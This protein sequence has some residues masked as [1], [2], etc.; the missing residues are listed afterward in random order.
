M[1][2]PMASRLR[3]T[4]IDDIA[5]QSHLLGE[6]APL[7]RA[8]EE[9]QQFSFVLWGGP[10]TGKTTIA[11]IYA[12]AVG[13]MLFEL[14]AVSAKKSDVQKVLAFGSIEAPP[15]LFLDEIHRFT[16]AQ[17]DV[18]LP[19]LETG[20]IILIGATTENPSFEVNAALLSRMRVFPLYPLSHDELL[21]IADRTEIPLSNEV[22]DIL[23]RFASGDARVL[24]STIETVQATYG[25]VTEETIESVVH[26]SGIRYDKKGDAHYDI[27]SALI[28]SMRASQPDAALYYLARM[29]A[30]GED[31]KF[32]A[33]RLVIFASEDIGQAAP[34]ALVVANEVFRAVE[35]IGLPEAEINLAHG[36]VYLAEAQ[37]DR[38]AYDAYRKAQADALKYGNLSIPYMIRNA[39][40]KSMKEEGYGAGYDMYTDTSFLPDELKGKRYYE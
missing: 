40:T 38:R 26:S 15:V 22:K 32:I 24:L 35:T 1:T 21:N 23:A 33:R 27:I 5:G 20:S 4:T 3:P 31:P 7:R 37:K 25:E 6:G 12:N 2:E 13:S 28:K 30:A 19:H 18:L 8:I 39:P 10:G 9:G 34:T 16:K 36:V 29:I 14:S 17:Q 11:R